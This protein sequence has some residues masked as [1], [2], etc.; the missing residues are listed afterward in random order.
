MGV[1]FD[2][3]KIKKQFKRVIDI[4]PDEKYFL[5]MVHPNTTDKNDIQM[6]VVLNAVES[7]G[8]KA[9]VFYPNVDANNSNILSDIAKFR[10]N[11]KF[12]M[13]RHMPLEGFIHTMAHCCCMVGNSSAGIRE[14]ASFGVPVINIGSRQ[15]GRERNSNVIDVECDHDKLSSELTCL[16]CSRF[17]KENLYYQKDS[18]KRIAKKIVEFIS[19]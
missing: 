12:Y 4:K 10:K 16:I 13:I 8:L 11:E 1:C 7:F 17:D 15:N 18:S 9:F 19:A 5:V 14:A 3:S 6:D 2:R